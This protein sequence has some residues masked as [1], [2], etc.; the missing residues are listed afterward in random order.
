M[1]AFSFCV[2]CVFFMR[3]GRFLQGISSFFFAEFKKICQKLSESSLNIFFFMTPVRHLP[4]IAR[5]SSCLFLNRIRYR[6][7]DLR[8]PC[9]GL[10][11]AVGIR[12]GYSFPKSIFH[13][14]SLDFIFGISMIES[15]TAVLHQVIRR[16]DKMKTTKTIAAKM[17]ISFKMVF[18]IRNV[19][20]R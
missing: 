5:M 9:G 10:P 19:P 1:L 2:F 7:G 3:C 11:E 13:S 17:A 18:F 4:P 8:A 12:G 6:Q 20:L 16:S 15:G 14:L